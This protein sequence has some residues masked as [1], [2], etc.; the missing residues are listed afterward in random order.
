MEFSSDYIAKVDPSYCLQV[1]SSDQEDAAE[2]AG[3]VAEAFNGGL[4]DKAKPRYPDPATPGNSPA[5][6]A[7]VASP[8]PAPAPGPK[9]GGFMKHSDSSFGLHSPDSFNDDVQVM[10]V[11][12]KLRE[13][14]NSKRPPLYI[15]QHFEYQT[16]H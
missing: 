2:D 4:V 16:W 12:T 5:R 13:I 3:R 10:K 8:A 6:G 7:T 1:G 11:S 14:H 15:T 9:Q